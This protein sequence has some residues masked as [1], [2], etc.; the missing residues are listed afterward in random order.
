VWW[1]KYG[2][3][4]QGNKYKR[5]LGAVEKWATSVPAIRCKSSLRC[6]TLRAF[7]YYPAAIEHLNIYSALSTV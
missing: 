4:W 1:N 5:G 3:Q 6:A 2:K 7:R